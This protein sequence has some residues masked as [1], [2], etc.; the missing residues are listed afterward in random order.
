MQNGFFSILVLAA[1]QGQVTYF[2]KINKQ[3]NPTNLVAVD[4]GK[5][6]SS[7]QSEID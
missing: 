6:I 1:I 4:S 3:R 2:K 7:T 5:G